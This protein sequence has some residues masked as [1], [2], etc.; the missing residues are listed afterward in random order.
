MLIKFNL[1]MYAYW[2]ILLLVALYFYF[3]LTHLSPYDMTESSLA[4]WEYFVLSFFPAFSLTYFDWLTYFLCHVKFGGG[5]HTFVNK[6][7]KSLK[8]NR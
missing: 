2:T 4:L 8:M 7:V 5:A 1:G 6:K 3:L